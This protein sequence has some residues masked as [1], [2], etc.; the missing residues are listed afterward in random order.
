MF[1]IKKASFS[2]LRNKY[3]KAIKV[4]GTNKHYNRFSE[5]EYNARNELNERQRKA[6]F[7]HITKY[8]ILKLPKGFSNYFRYCSYFADKCM[9]DYDRF[10]TDDHYEI[11]SYYLKYGPQ[12][13]FFD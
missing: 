3:L 12:I 7:K 13:V 6:I 8:C 4:N 1:N 11:D 10:E 9:E 5:F 2:E